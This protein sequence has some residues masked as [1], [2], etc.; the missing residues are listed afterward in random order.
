MARRATDD[1]DAEFRQHVMVFF[2]RKASEAH[3]ALQTLMIDKSFAFGG[4][5]YRFCWRL[6]DYLQKLSRLQP[7]YETYLPVRFYAQFD[8][9]W[10]PAFE[11]FEGNG[12]WSKWIRG[13]FDEDLA[14]E[15]VK[16]EVLSEMMRAF[17]DFQ[18]HDADTLI[19]NKG[20]D[21]QRK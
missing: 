8:D 4:K 2:V 1:L 20:V 15:R 7:E 9:T 14:D 13:H 16:M 12:W 6:V 21:Q 3:Q 10:L 19:H 18:A 5:Q 11:Y 17:P